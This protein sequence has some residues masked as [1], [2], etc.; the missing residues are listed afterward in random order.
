MN[1][2]WRA[3][4]APV[5]G[6]T[7]ISRIAHQ[8]STVPLWYEQHAETAPDHWS[9]TAAMTLCFSSG[10]GW[11]FWIEH[12]GVMVPDLWRRHCCACGGGRRGGGHS[13]APNPI[14]TERL[15]R[16]TCS[17]Q[18][19]ELFLFLVLSFNRI[20]LLIISRTSL[21]PYFNLSWRAGEIRAL[22]LLLCSPGSRR[23]AAILEETFVLL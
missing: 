7:C 1:H 14:S 16:L 20:R 12:M 21:R 15:K 8:S 2:C 10:I 6:W 23:H 19:A 22:W 18:G 3:F 11:G 17:G 9:R 5:S 4:K 13:P